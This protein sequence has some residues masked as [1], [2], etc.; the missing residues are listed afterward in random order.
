MYIGFVNS[1]TLELKMQA[2][3]VKDMYDNQKICSELKLALAAKGFSKIVEIGSLTELGDA[4]IQLNQDQPCLLYHNIFTRYSVDPVTIVDFQKQHGFNSLSIDGRVIS[5]LP[6]EFLKLHHNTSSFQFSSFKNFKVENV[7]SSYVLPQEKPM[8]FL[9]THNRD[10]YLKLTLNSLDFSLIEK[11]PIKILLNKP[12]DS[13]KMVALDFAAG[14]NYV[15]VLESKENTFITATNVLLQW[16]R[17]EKFII[18]EDDFILPYTTKSYFPNWP[19]QFLDR[20]N[21][22][23]AVGWS[24]FIENTHV[25]FWDLPRWPQEVKCMSDWEIIDPLSRTLM[26][27]QALAV[28]T[29]FYV[30]RAKKA[31]DKYVC[32]FDS[33]LNSPKKCTP[34]LRGYHI[35]F[36]Q[37]MDGFCDLRRP[38]WPDPVNVC[39]VTSLLTGEERQIQPQK[40][41]EW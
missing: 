3:I 9:Y 35:G 8:I 19:F 30:E 36:N 18:M 25:P 20:L 15:E 11:V 39:H 31:N 16:F 14:K 10:M 29:D 5:F 23:D 32:N 2:V 38:R 22:F 28:R 17:P 37:E 26:M 34:S 24:V 27:A 12:T 40:L 13:V 21:Y 33:T 6:S 1:P 41:L 4:K 7:T